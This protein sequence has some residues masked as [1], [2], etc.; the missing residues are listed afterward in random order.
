MR[1][2][3]FAAFLAVLLMSVSAWAQ[4]DPEPHELDGEDWQEVVDGD[5]YIDVERGDPNRGEA[6]GII[7][8][9][10]DEVTA[11]ILDY[12]RFDEWYPGQ[13]DPRLLELD[14]ASGNA[15]AYGEVEMP[16]PVRN[17]TY[18]VDV[19]GGEGTDAAGNPYNWLRWNYVE[20]TGNLDELYGFWYITPYG[21]NGEHT[22]V[23]YVVYADM[24]VWVP[25]PVIRWATRRML[26]GIIEGLR[27]RHDE[28]Y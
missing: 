11:I 15:R 1:L 4:A 16:W 5:V 22:L 19:E 21:A 24:G 27:E 2:M 17:R 23:R 14:E 20:G 18:E 9:P 7:E 6:V 3:R 13:L 28:L 10:M 12:E 26:P 8:A 25:D